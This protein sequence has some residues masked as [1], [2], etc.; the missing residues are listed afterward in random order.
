MTMSPEEELELVRKAMMEGRTVKG[1]CEWEDAAYRRVKASADLAGLDPDAIRKLVVEFVA[2]G[3]TI[4]QVKEQ[5]PEYSNY[6]F[7]H[8]VILP[9]P[10]LP[11]GFF[12]EIRLFDPDVDCPTVLLVNAHP[13]RK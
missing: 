12:V 13:Q 4:R 6:E 2:G 1:C 10:A 8:N 11:D 7:Y 9:M 5:R 3:G